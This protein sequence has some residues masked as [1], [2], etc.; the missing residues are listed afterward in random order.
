[1]RLIKFDLRLFCLLVAVCLLA[2][3]RAFPQAPPTPA[4]QDSIAAAAAVVDVLRPAADTSDL[5][6][7]VAVVL[8]VLSFLLAVIVIASGIAI[9][10]HCVYDFYLRQLLHRHWV[11]DFL[12]ARTHTKCGP[13]E[14]YPPPPVPSEDVQSD[15]AWE[16][17]LS[18][19]N[20]RIKKWPQTSYGL[21][22][23]QLCGQISA[24]FD[25]T[26]ANRLNQTNP[27]SGER[28]ALRLRSNADRLVDELQVSLA[29]HW[30]H[31][32]FLGALVVGELL[33]MIWVGIPPLE[34]LGSPEVRWALTRL[35]VIGTFIALLVSQ[36]RPWLERLS[37]RR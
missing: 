30:K 16:K 4:S 26:I 15:P 28:E 11:Q 9:G 10:L 25:T 32:D 27:D 17:I 18:E 34:R 1:M 24:W 36:I 22:P 14:G 37:A 6:R 35:I 13:N 21:I 8:T 23:A 29:G 33:Y 2:P 31:I 7:P 12:A 20:T 19:V 5:I 3:S